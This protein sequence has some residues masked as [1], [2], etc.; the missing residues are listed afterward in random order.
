MSTAN[1]AVWLYFFGP[2][3]TLLLFNLVLF[4]YASIKLIIIH[5]RELQTSENQGNRKKNNNKNKRRS[6]PCI[7]L[8]SVYYELN[9][10]L[11]LSLFLIDF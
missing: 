6:V 11:H 4:V 2:I 7:F 5:R 8:H 10:S 9:K 1:Q 3:G